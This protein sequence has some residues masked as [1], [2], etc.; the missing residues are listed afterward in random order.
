MS[1]LLGRLQVAQ[2]RFPRLRGN[3]GVAA[4]PGS[5][6]VWDREAGAWITCDSAAAACPFADT[7]PA[8]QLPQLLN[9]TDN[10]VASGNGS[11]SNS[12]GAGSVRVNRAPFVGMSALVG[13]VDVRTPSNYRTAAFKFFTQ[14][15]WRG[16]RV[17]VMAYGASVR[18]EAE[19]Q[20]QTGVLPLLEPANL[21][22]RPQ[23]PIPISNAGFVTHFATCFGCCPSH[24]TS[25]CSPAPASLSS[26]LSSPNVSWAQLLDPTSAIGPFRL[27]H[28]DP[29]SMGRWRAGGYDN[30]DLTVRLGTGRGGVERKGASGKGAKQ[31][32]CVSGCCYCKGVARRRPW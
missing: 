3:V 23:L 28:L 18:L 27:Q 7:V 21:L 4:L 13:A 25:P 14:V 17:V 2:L 22:A 11:S 1:P 9:G 6:V 20:S 19:A 8:L 31:R 5:Q 24:H 10:V 30:T 29:A 12:S 26:Q 15:R 16:S 32:V